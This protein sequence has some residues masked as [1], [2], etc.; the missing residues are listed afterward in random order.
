MGGGEEGICA[1]KT[2]AKP[3]TPAFQ[4]ILEEEGK[5][6]VEW[7]EG[8]HVFPTC[9][10]KPV[11]SRQRQTWLLDIYSCDKRRSEITDRTRE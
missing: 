11:D 8:F 9:K 10:M 6:G 3:V 5:T 2:K 1:V 4:R 7:G